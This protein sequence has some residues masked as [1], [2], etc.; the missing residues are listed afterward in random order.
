MLKQLFFFTVNDTEILS[1]LD[2][3]KNV[4]AS[5]TP[6]TDAVQPLGT[7]I[8]HW[9]GVQW[10]SSY[11]DQEW[12]WSLIDFTQ[13]HLPLQQQSWLSTQTLLALR[14]FGDR[15]MLFQNTEQLLSLLKK[16]LFCSADSWDLWSGNCAT[17]GCLSLQTTSQKEMRIASLWVHPSSPS[18]KI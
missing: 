4:R 13:R 18:P 10:V 7:L 12:V 16:F 1:M 17:W 6:A 15:S 9:P 11:T 5:W 14:H 2:V 8:L 3:S